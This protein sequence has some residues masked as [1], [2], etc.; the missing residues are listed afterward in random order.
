MSQIPPKQITYPAVAITVEPLPN[1]ARALIV[2]T[3]YGEVLVFPM[4]AESAEEV[5]KHLCAPAV[6]LP[7]QN[8]AMQ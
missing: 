4:S 1:G 7:G 3:P 2:D 8:E 5:G 6:V